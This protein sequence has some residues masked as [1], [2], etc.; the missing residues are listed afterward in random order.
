[1]GGE[2]RSYRNVRFRLSPLMDI[3]LIRKANLMLLLQ[4]EENG[5]DSIYHDAVK[6]RFAERAGV[7]PEQLIGI[8]SGSQEFTDDVA[9]QIERRL[10]LPSGWLDADNT[11]YPGDQDSDHRHQRMNDLYRAAPPAVQEALKNGHGT[12][13][14]GQDGDVGNSANVTSSN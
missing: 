4:Q 12:K 14:K 3:H 2:R 8:E 5:P 13:E 7:R 1:M 11:A 10:S 9:R 6:E